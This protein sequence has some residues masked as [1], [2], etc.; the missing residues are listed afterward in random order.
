MS[1]PPPDRP[2]LAH[3]VFDWNGTLLDDVGLAV[4]SVNSVL[5]K[6]G[7]PAID[8][9][10]YRRHFTFP[11]RDFYQR[12]GFDFSALT[13]EAVMTDYLGLFD[14]EVLRCSL[15]RG[16]TELLARLADAGVQCSILSASHSATLQSSLRHFGLERHFLHRV[17]LPDAQAQGKLALA[18][19]LQRSLAVP[20]GQVL[21]V[22]DTLHD[23][24]VANALGW[25]CLVIPNGH[26]CRSRFSAAEV[27]FADEL[28]EVDA[29]IWREET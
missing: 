20:C 4:R 1:R 8:L 9:E 7:R 14:R 23:V 22:G 27:Q 10:H 29:R 19:E 21:Y 6:H 13:F 16:V 28:G 17:G 12:L 25:R 15:H 24:E 11:I 3:V 26:Q 5:A 18:H 2:S